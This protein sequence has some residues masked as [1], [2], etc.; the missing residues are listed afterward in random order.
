MDWL[1]AG[2]ELLISPNA[3]VAALVSFRDPVIDEALRSG[4]IFLKN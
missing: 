1:S 3:R 2:A 4:Q